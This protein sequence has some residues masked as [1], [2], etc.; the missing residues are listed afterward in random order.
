MKTNSRSISHPLSL[1]AQ[2]SC[3]CH[4]KRELQ[5]EL[6]LHFHIPHPPVIMDYCCEIY[7]TVIM[8]FCCEIYFTARFAVYCD[9][10]YPTKIRVTQD[11]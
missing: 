5:L 10:V 2:Q 7:V 1:S 4:L 9:S 6:I 11:N 3:Q 8:D